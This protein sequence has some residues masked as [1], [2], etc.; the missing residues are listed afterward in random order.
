MYAVIFEVWPTEE[1]TAEYLEIAAK[2]K[3]FLADQEGFV[4]IERFKSLAEEGKLLSLS[5]WESEAAIEKW[6]NMLE[7][8]HGQQKGK[9]ELFHS[10]RIRVAEVV[11]DYTHARQQDAG[12][13][14]G[15]RHR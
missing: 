11:R 4:S 8:R 10:Y 5:F 14:V 3:S 9:E 7:H 6:R 13:H 15:G 12:I 1:G 2:L